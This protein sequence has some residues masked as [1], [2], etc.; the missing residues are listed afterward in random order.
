MHLHDLHGLEVRRSSGGEA[1][2]EHGSDTEVRR[3][4]AADSRG[5]V[6]PIT[7]GRQALIVETGCAHHWMDPGADGELEIAHHR[8]GMGEVDHHL[9]ALVDQFPQVVADIE[10]GDRLQAGGIEQRP[11]HLGTH[12]PSGAQH[13]HA[14]RHAGI[15]PPE[16]TR[17]RDG[18]RRA[19]T[20]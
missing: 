6:E 10:A 18:A 12:A 4:H 11:D 13:S 20:P 5:P 2:H 8:L 19:L 16:W 17:R 3:D 1:H 9:G 15:V 14:N 7:Y